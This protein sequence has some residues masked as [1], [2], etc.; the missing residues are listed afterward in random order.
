MLF[1]N[2]S[3]NKKIRA[4]ADDDETIKIKCWRG[5]LR[6]SILESWHLQC[7]SCFNNKENIFLR[8]LFHDE[9]IFKHF[10]SAFP[11]LSRKKSRLTL[12]LSLL[13]LRHLKFLSLL[14][15]RCTNG[16][17]AVCKL[18]WQTNKK[19]REILFSQ[20]KKETVFCLRLLRFVFSSS[21]SCCRVN[22]RFFASDFRLVLLPRFSVCLSILALKWEA[23]IIFPRNHSRFSLNSAFLHRKLIKWSK[24][25]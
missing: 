17:M 25:I 22:A 15:V 13:F 9:T 12:F 6:H 8:L 1:H 19:S 16:C 7:S 3:F 20:N 10:S 11:F 18:L 24:Q 23:F 14:L 2:H 4:V 5:C 21:D